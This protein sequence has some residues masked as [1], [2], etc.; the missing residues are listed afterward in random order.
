MS[1]VINFYLWFKVILAGARVGLLLLAG[2][3]IY[4]DSSVFLEWGFYYR[5]RREM[6]M[7]VYFD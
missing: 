6:V 7:G 3:L 1:N 2:A 4:Y 5:V